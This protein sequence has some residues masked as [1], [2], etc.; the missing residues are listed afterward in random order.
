MNLWVKRTGQLLL[1]ALF[2]IA[3]EDDSFLLGFKNQNKK[4]S[5]GYQEFLIGEG[6]VLSVDSIFTDN[7]GASSTKRLLIGEYADPLLG[8]V[9]TEAYVEFLPVST[10][11][12]AVSPTLYNYEFDSL[13]LRLSLD[14]Y[15]YGLVNEGVSNFKVHRITEDTLYYNKNITLKIKNKNGDFVDSVVFVPGA[16]TNRYYSN[17]TV[18]YNESESLGEARLFKISRKNGEEYLTSAS[19]KLSKLE[20]GQDTLLAVARLD[21]TYGLELFNVAKNDFNS[22]FSNPG[23]FRNLFKGFALIP[24][25]GSNAVVGYNPINSMSRLV[26]YYHTTENGDVKDTL[27]RAFYPNASFHNISTN[28]T[29]ELPNPDPAY[30]GTDPGSGMR[31]VQSGNALVTKIDLN[32]FYTQFADTVQD[33][34]VINSAEL[35]IQSV[36]SQNGYKPISNFELRVMKENDRYA[37]YRINEDSISFSGYNFALPSYVLPTTYPRFHYFV[38]D[39]SNS[40]ARLSYSSSKEKYSGFTSLF[41]QNLLDRARENKKTPDSPKPLIRYLGLYPAGEIGKSVN[42]TV[43]NKSNI[44]LRIYYTYPNKTNL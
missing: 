1:A 34:I 30:T 13:V 29:A 7:S 22:E 43:F 11:K 24:S 5:V 15:S 35:L 33:K 10:G 36:P 41:F 37:D 25:V 39:D 16:I 32:N 14:S 3:C 20:A 21:D 26:L 27:S 19:L 18:G 44:K 23:K 38:F 17:S 9:R 12:L 6:T 2:L 31:A 8:S 42:R 28:R 4:F 40:G